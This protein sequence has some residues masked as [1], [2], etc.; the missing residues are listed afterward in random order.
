MSSKAPLIPY[1]LP[2]L[3]QALKD[4]LVA[5]FLHELPAPRGAARHL[6]ADGT[7]LEAAEPGRSDKA[8]SRV[9]GGGCCRFMRVTP[10]KMGLHFII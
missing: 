6:V 4:G 1:I 3:H 5:P 9:K 2:Q 10:Q 7:L 8:L